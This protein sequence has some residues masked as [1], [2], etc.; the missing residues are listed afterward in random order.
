MAL[1]IECTDCGRLIGQVHPLRQVLSR[2]VAI[3]VLWRRRAIK[4]IKGAMDCYQNHQVV[5][6][7]QC[8]FF[9]VAPIR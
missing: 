9:D 3:G 8:N 5:L 2:P 1:R 4:G 6:I 7:V